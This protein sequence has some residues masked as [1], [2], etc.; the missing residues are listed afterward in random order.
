MQICLYKLENLTLFKELPT[1]LLEVPELS[2]QSF[3]WIITRD[4]TIEE[5]RKVFDLHFYDFLEANLGYLR[6]VEIL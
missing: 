4:Y 1:G 6:S 3:R 2:E 5:A